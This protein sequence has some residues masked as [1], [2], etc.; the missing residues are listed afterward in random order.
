[1]V[2]RQQVAGTFWPESTD[3]RAAS[4]LRSALSRLDGPVRRAVKVTAVDLGV[5]EGVVVDVRHSGALA[6]RL[7]DRHASPSETDIGS[8]AVSSLY[9]GGARAAA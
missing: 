2:T 5:A 4:N 6:R 1:V 9:C 3:E 7:I 8:P